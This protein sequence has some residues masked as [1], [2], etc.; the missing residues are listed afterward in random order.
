MK[1]EDVPLDE[2]DLIRSV[3]QDSF[4]DFVKEFW[5]VLIP[6]VP[7]W[8]WHIEYLCDEMQA[9]AERVFENKPKEHDLI[10][11]VPPGTTKSTIISVMFPPWTWTRMPQARHINSSHTQNLVLDLSRK[12][13]DIVLS[14]LYQKCWPHIKLREDQNTK[15]HF[16]NTEGGFRFSCTVGGSSPMGFHAHFLS[17]DDP[18]DPQ[19]A[20]SELELATANNFMTQTLP[21]RKVNKEVSVTVLVMQRLHQNDPTGHILEKQRDNVKLI[22]LPGELADNVRPKRLK[23][24]YVNGLLDPIRL[25]HRALAESL[26][27][28]GQYAYAGQ[29]QQNPVPAG[30]G[31]FKTS[32]L[33]IE[34]V[35]PKYFK[36]IVRYWDKAGTSKGGAFTV[37]V[38]MGLEKIPVGNGK[39]QDGRYWVL[40]VIRGQWDASEREAIIKQ[41]AR[42]DG[43]LTK[44]GVEQEPG[45]GGKE[46]AE[47]TAKNLAGYSVS[48]DKVTGDKETRA[49]V[50]ATQVNAGNV[51]LLA[52]K[53]NHEYI[54]EL[55][56]FPTSTY[57]DQVDASS[58][59]FSMLF[60]KKVSIGKL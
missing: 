54:E 30:G 23:K 32:R 51:V 43:H 5:H 28:M 27:T 31:M 8:N 19:K 35:P 12:C 34:E 59:A 60:K 41:T 25:S 46:S 13:R 2:V 16:I 42:A 21:T 58:G 48:L 14:E 3:C 38:E 55:K 11:N 47:A 44:I 56:Y 53:W 39:W 49:D 29:I 52:G 40:D 6:D 17:V 22:C 15:G 10:I 45:S 24:K 57:K 9:V 20:I 26:K 1:P 18:I 33:Q 37:G 50:F 4:Y 7:V 36:R